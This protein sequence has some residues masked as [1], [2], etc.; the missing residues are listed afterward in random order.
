MDSSARA[1]LHAVLT[2]MLEQ[3]H[4]EEERQAQRLAAIR[5]LEQLERDIDAGLAAPVATALLERRL[6]AILALDLGPTS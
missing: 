1:E 3:Y 6:A 2:R 5:V 4:R